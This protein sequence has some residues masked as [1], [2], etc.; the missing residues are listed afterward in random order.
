[1][2]ELFVY[3][4]LFSVEYGTSK[5]EGG[6]DCDEEGGRGGTDDGGKEFAFGAKLSVSK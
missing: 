1:M 4:T 6:L 2:K 3:A 5:L